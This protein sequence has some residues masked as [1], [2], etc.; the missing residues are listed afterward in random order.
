VKPYRIGIV[1]Y[2]FG[3]VHAE[4]YRQ[5]PFYTDVGAPIELVGVA[6]SRPETAEKAKKAEGGFALATADWREL[7]TSPEVDIVHVCTPDD[8]HHPIASAALAAGKHVYCEKPL[9]RTV[10][11]AEDLCARAR[12]SGRVAQVAFQMRFG[13]AAQAA[14]R[15]IQDGTLGEITSFRVTFLHSG[16]E[17][18]DR[19]L[20]WRL[21]RTRAG[22]GVLYDL[23]SHA[24]DLITFLLGRPRRVMGLTR[25]YIKERPAARGSTRRVPVGVDDV[26]LALL[27][28]EAGAVGLLEATRLA[29]GLRRGPDVT[30]Y[31]TRGSVAFNGSTNPDELSLYLK[32]EKAPGLSGWER[33]NTGG[34]R[35]VPLHVAAQGHF[36]EAIRDGRTDAEPSFESGLLVQRVLA[37]VQESDRAGEWVTVG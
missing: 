7:V 19:P 10:A 3:R 21:D 22:G 32:A 34:R 20:T 11:E 16:Y 6:T 15:L 1:G 28:T 26:A 17:D 30:I 2:S 37:A 8:L 31:G 18:P 27:E 13:S 9:A 25:T 23:G 36:L 35:P 12:A 4:A 33:I 14:R 24:I 5:L 29:T